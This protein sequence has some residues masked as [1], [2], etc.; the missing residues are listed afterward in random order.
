MFLYQLSVGGVGFLGGGGGVE[1]QVI[2]LKWGFI[3]EELTRS[4]PY[5]TIVTGRGITRS[6][7]TPVPTWVTIFTS[8]FMHGG[9]AAGSL[10]LAAIKMAAREP[11]KPVNTR[12]QYLD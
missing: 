2:F 8:M 6:I 7:E 9:F 4:Q 3:P 5:T 1:A 11:L 10:I 12:R